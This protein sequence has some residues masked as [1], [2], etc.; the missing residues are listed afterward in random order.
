M[1][2]ETEAS[3]A[4][5]EEDAAL[6]DEA[7]GRSKKKL[8]LLIAIPL[9]VVG[10]GV[11]AWQAHLL[12][13]GKGG[14]KAAAHGGAGAKEAPGARILLSVPSATANLD[15]GA[16]RTV[17][18][19]MTASIEFEGAE[20]EASLKDR[21]PEVEDIFQTY[22]HESRP[23]DLHGSGF[24]RLREA[25]LRRLRVAFAPVNVSN[26]YITELLTQ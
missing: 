4:G 5:A 13:F 10:G 3:V 18:V 24:Y 21:L 1:S 23:Q 11:G 26:V 8:A 15:N 19:K 2:D 6:A 12:P 16:G 25:L 17:Y 9:L 22:L 14:E 20:S 7:K